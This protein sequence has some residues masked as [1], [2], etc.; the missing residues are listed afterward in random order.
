MGSQ[1]TWYKEYNMGVDV[2]DKEH[3][4][5]FKILDKLFGLWR[6][7]KD[8]QWLC[9]EGLKFFEGHALKH[10]A[11]EEAYMDSI[12]YI[13]LKQHKKIHKGFKEDTLP[14]LEKELEETGHSP[15]AV[16]HFLGVCSG[17]L[18][19]HMLSEDLAIIGKGIRKWENLLPEEE[20][21]AMKN[22]VAQS[23]HSMFHLESKLISDTYHGE[24]FGEGVY[25]R[26]AYG[27]GKEKARQEFLLAFEERLLVNT[28]GMVMGMQT[29]KLD[30]LLVHASRYTTRQFVER[31]MKHFPSMDEYEL[32]EENILS[33]EQFQ[34]VM[35]KEKLQVSLLFN[36]GQGYFAYCILSP[37]LLE[38]GTGI[39]ALE[40]KNAT[41]AVEKYLTDREAQKKEEELHPKKKIIIVDDSKTMRAIMKDALSTDYEV[42]LAESGM[43]AIMNITLNRPD[44]VLLD[45]EMP[46]CDGKQVLEMLRSEEAF[47]DLPVIFLTG[48]G[49][50]E[51]IKKIMHLKPA[52]YLLKKLKPEEIK[53]E[54][55]AFFHKQKK[56]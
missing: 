52:G 17:W 35:E 18:I 32:K 49:D 38:S 8:N 39:A 20:V 36:T 29:K 44:L 33:Y 54:I 27:K 12:H 14:A 15:E 9:Q 53:K 5:L 23:M 47:T 46:I 1:F 31:M 43:T 11:H 26:L 30:N 37:H 51:S 16:E 50:M 6:E 25:Y 7:E 13:G 48:K 55:D 2:I 19:G 10:F 21:E 41:E 4:Q 45:Y 22:T 34:K 42:S 24:K 3:Q 40:H 56:A 28:V